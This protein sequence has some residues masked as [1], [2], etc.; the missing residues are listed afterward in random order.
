MTSPYMHRIRN[1]IQ[2][3]TK[4]TALCLLAGLLPS[5][6]DAAQATADERPWTWP[7]DPGPTIHEGF[8]PPDMPWG[9]GH[10]GIDLAGSIGQLVSAVDDGTVT[11][12]GVVAG[13]GVVVVSHGE[14]RSTYEPVTSTV[15]RGDLVS[16][17]QPIGLLQGVQSHC[18]PAVCLHLG[19]RLGNEYIDPEPLLGFP[20]IRLK[21][22]S[23]LPSLLPPL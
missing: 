6:A 1:R 11:F 5:L 8:D 21:P 15:T 17:G 14:I 16:A 12:A 10:R 4:I 13:R 7:L 19:A 3:I 20:E 23:A 2:T 9:S 18:Q 22:D